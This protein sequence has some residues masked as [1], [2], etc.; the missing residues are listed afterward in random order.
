MTY[1][2]SFLVANRDDQRR[3]YTMFYRYNYDVNIYMD[4]TIHKRN[5]FMLS[6]A[7]IKNF[8]P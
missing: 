7:S 1:Q 5:V 3:K 6:M 4:I 8:S 2:E